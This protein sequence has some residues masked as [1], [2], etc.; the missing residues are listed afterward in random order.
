[1]VR[2]DPNGLAAAALT[3]TPLGVLGRDPLGNRE[4]LAG[5]LNPTL[6]SEPWVRGIA[7]GPPGLA[8]NALEPP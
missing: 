1:M 5:Y 6:E 7:L 4:F 8:P 2:A 3:L